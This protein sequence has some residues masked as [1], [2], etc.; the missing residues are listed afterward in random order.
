[1]VDAQRLALLEKRIGPPLSKELL[2]SLALSHAALEGRGPDHVSAGLSMAFFA[3]FDE[4]GVR[5]PA[6]PLDLVPGGPGRVRSHEERMVI[7][8]ALSM[9]DAILEH[10][11]G[12]LLSVKRVK[13]W[14]EEKRPTCATLILNEGSVL[15]CR[16]TGR[17]RWDFPK[18]ILDEGETPLQGALRELFEKTSLSI[19]PSVLTN[20]GSHPFVPRQRM[21][22]FAVDAA[23]GAFDLAVVAVD[24]VAPSIVAEFDAEPQ[25]VLSDF[26]FG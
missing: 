5:L 15:M 23:K 10:Y 14:T 3:T 20:L 22:A 18:G 17:G 21:H 6:T 9:T 13:A 25:R 11:E 8:I 12:P 24:P 2:S 7:K 16:Q 4:H 26:L 1:M 19:E